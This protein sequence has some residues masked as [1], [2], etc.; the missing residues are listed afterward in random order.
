MG[1]VRDTGNLSVR[2]VNLMNKK[3]LRAT[4][5]IVLNCPEPSICKEVSRKGFAG[6]RHNAF[7]YKGLKISIHRPVK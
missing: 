1:Y 3:D 4:P 7:I 2:G 6:W 5:E